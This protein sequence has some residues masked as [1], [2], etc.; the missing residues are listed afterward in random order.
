MYDLDVDDPVPQQCT[1]KAWQPEVAGIAEAFHAHIV[2]WGY[3]RHSH[4]TWAVLIVDRGAIDYS[5][6]RKP[7]AAVDDVVAIL[8]PGVTHDGRPARRA[9]QGFWKRALYLDH[10]ALAPDLIGP[11]VDQATITDPELRAL[12]SALH[13]ALV[14][15]ERLEAEARLAVA[16]DRIRRH[17]VRSRSQ[18]G[19]EQGIAAT[20]R[21]LLDEDPAGC[22][23]TEAGRTLDRTVAHL[24]RSFT[25]AYGVSPHQYTI[26]RRVDTARRLLLAGRPASGR[27]GGGRWLLRPGPPD[28]SLQASPVGHPRGLCRQRTLTQ[29]STFAPVG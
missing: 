17:L 16:C 25:A 7:C 29:V 8:P 11:A 15:G 6:D 9:R 10:S 21:H 18:P 12:I 27:G 1:V 14:G 20:L 24:V 22:S 2:D 3:P 19:P 5:L 4:D 23:L 28:P 13:H 26:G